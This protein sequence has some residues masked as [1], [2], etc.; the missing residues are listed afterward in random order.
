RSTSGDTH[1]GGDDFDKTLLEWVL[2]NTDEALRA[3]IRTSPQ[4]LQRLNEAI[5]RAKRD[6]SERNEVEISLPFL[7]VI[8][9]DSRHFEMTLGRHQLEEVLEP[10]FQRCISPLQKALEMAALPPAEA[11][12]VLLVGGSTRIPRVRALVQ[13]TFTKKEPNR[14][15]S[16]DEVVAL[17]A[18]VQG[19]ILNGTI[20]DLVLLD[21]TP[22]P[23]GIETKG[24]VM[25][26]IVE[27][28]TTIPARQSQFFSTG[29]HFQRA[30]DVVILQ[31]EERVA[32]KNQELGRFTLEG[33][34][35]L[36]RGDAQIEVVFDIDENGILT[37]VALDHDSKREE[38][39]VIEGV[40]SLSSADKKKMAT[41]I[42]KGRK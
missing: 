19:A 1:L 27:K 28:N 18:A 16:A 9:G 17:G 13:E 40:T 25:T 14:S 37:V 33:I 3:A 24:G 35:K 2:E 11:N 23:L 6:L 31:G 12:E 7:S 26:V 36:V 38:R 32:Q 21:V 10:M 29:D 42:R 5:E 20:E 39:L 34:R 8:D 30:A 15:V 22:F 41:S 4:A